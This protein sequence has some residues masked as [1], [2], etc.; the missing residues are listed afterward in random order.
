MY[1]SPSFFPTGNYSDSV[2]SYSQI[3]TVFI[4][5]GTACVKGT[6]KAPV[7]DFLRPNNLTGF[8]TTI[9]TPKMNSE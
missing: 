3:P 5:S 7:V 8:E 2:H 6:A 1:Q 4:F 9:V